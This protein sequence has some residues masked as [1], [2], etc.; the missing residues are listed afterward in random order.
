[1]A[2]LN[3]IIAVEKGVKGHAFSRLS[4]MNKIIQKPDLF[5]GVTRVYRPR[6]ENGERLP[7]ERKHVQYN[8]PSILADLRTFFGDHLDT[9]ARKDWANTAA[10]ANINIGG[11]TVIAD[12]PVTHLL[13]L[14]KQMTDLRTFVS[15]LPVLD[16]SEEWTADANS[17]LFRTNPT[18]TIRTK[19]EQRP[20]VLYDAT[21]KHPA[22]T[23]LITEDVTVGTWA[24][25]RISGAMPK[26]DKIKMIERIDRMIRAI[27]EAREE[28]NGINEVETPAVGDALFGFIFADAA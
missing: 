12:V 11:T 17:G 2:R 27:K 20:V 18:E 13:F 7:S 25:T 4:D 28:A 23:Q 16:D 3:Q 21:D 15:N 6:D 14:E 1:M 9:T 8:V 24:A 22:Q 19:K 10:R 26:P 5:N